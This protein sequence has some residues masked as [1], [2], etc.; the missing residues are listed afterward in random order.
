MKT[1]LVVCITLGFIAGFAVQ[2]RTVCDL[3]AQMAL[4]ASQVHG[5]RTEPP[6]GAEPGSTAWERSFGAEPAAGALDQRLEKLERAVSQLARASD[7]LMERGDVPLTPNK[8]RDLALRFLDD[9]SGD[10]ERVQALKVL[11]ENGML[12]DEVVENAVSWLAST[13]NANVKSQGLRHLEGVTNK[14]FKDLL[15]GMLVDSDQR[16]RERC[17][18]NL[19]HFLNDPQVENSVWGLLKTDPS[20]DVRAQ[21]E[22]ELR[23]GPVTEARAGALRQRALDPGS[24]LDEKLLA[25][26]ALSHAA[27]EAPDVL[28]T[29]VNLSQTTSDPAER[30]RIFRAFDD[31]IHDPV[32]V[33]PLVSG[34]RDPSPEVRR[35]AADALSN[36]NSDPAVLQWLDYVSQNDA[37]PRVREK[38]RDALPKGKK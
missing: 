10:K 17:V 21:A 28:A 26:R 5:S 12:A 34:L 8:A 1:F 3:K 27:V 35:S 9:R 19:G 38:A 20:E 7:H 22:K 29:L 13:T 15:F 2:V 25:L 6:A 30:V 32:L 11:R 36:F 18:E 33:A 16:V 31:G 4:L 37:D 14:I 24:S 23:N